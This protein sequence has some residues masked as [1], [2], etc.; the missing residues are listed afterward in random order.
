MG[1]EPLDL[2]LVS[3]NSE[4]LTDRLVQHLATD[5][6][7]LITTGGVCD[8]RYDLLPDIF[9]KIGVKTCFRKVRMKP[10]KSLLFGEYVKAGKPKLVFGLPGN[11]VSAFVCCH[12]F[13]EAVF[14][15]LLDSPPPAHVRAALTTEV[16]KDDDKRHFLRGSLHF[17]SGDGVA[18]VTPMHR[19]SSSDLAALALANCLIVLEEDRRHLQA[20]EQVTCIMI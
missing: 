4:I 15:T 5:M 19:Q 12:R 6:D 17:A 9:A 7:I 10:G 13:L 11:P 1:H 2:G 3:D 18:S 16:C 14:S 20:K 8:G